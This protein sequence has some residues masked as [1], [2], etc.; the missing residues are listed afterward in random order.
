MKILLDTNILVSALIFGGKAKEYSGKLGC[1]FSA[2]ME[3]FS[4]DEPITECY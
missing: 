4:M 2:V 1:S 3:K